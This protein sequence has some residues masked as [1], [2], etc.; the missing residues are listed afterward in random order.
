MWLIEDK[1][2]ICCVE[3]EGNSSLE[4]KPAINYLP[5]SPNCGIDLKD[6]LFVGLEAEI[7]EYPWA[8]FLQ[9]TYRKYHNFD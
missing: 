4:I 1:N 8:A 5:T 7:D 6:H 2:F 3:P 9:Y